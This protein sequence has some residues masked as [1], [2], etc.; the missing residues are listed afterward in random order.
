MCVCVP[1]KIE[2]ALKF[3]SP[4][5]KC[6]IKMRLF[7]LFRSQLGT[8]TNH[9]SIPP[10]GI[11]HEGREERRRGAALII[12]VLN[13]THSRTMERRSIHIYPSYPSLY[14]L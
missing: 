9:S 6:G 7:L 5:Y 14:Y 2:K 11:T 10:S 1:H 12:T 13:E 3:L 8:V 4:G